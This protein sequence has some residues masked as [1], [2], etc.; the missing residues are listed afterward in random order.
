MIP[1]VGAQFP[2]PDPR[3]WLIFET[4]PADLQ[5]A[6]DARAVADYD[7]AH[8]GY[9]GRFTRS[10]TATE[11]ALLAHLGHT[12]PDELT[13]YVEYPTEGIRRRYWPALETQ[14]VAP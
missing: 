6:E 5:T 11:R 14:E 13:T 10:A 4:L 7:R 3:G 2:Q 12:V 9:S 8:E 1:G